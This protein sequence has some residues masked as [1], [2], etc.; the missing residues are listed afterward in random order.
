M[1]LA[2]FSVPQKFREIRQ[3]DED[4]CQPDDVVWIDAAVKHSGCNYGEN[5]TDNCPDDKDMQLIHR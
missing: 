1:I 4:D 3:P 5:K 2:R